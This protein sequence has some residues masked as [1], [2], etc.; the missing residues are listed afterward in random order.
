MDQADL[1]KQN[2]LGIDTVQSK[3][4]Y[5]FQTADYLHMVMNNKII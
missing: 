5:I 4:L 2:Y 1:K 3:N